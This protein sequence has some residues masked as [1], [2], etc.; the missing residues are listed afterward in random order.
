MIIAGTNNSTMNIA[1]MNDNITEGNETFNMSLTVPSLLNPRITAGAITSAT[2]T[3]VDTS[4]ENC[5]D[6]LVILQ[7]TLPYNWKIS[8]VP[9]FEDFK[10]LLKIKLIFCP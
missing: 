3:I 5:I 8:K 9:V 1:V 4:S 10:F 7:S 2:V 6:T